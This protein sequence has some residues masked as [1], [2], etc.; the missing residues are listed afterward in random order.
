VF[1]LRPETDVSGRTTFR[2]I[3]IM[4]D[5]DR[6]FFPADKVAN[7]ARTMIRSLGMDPDEMRTLDRSLSNGAALVQRLSMMPLQEGDVAG[8]IAG[9]TT[10]AALQTLKD[11]EDE[12]GK[13]VT[14]LLAGLE[15]VVERFS[16]LLGGTTNMF[17]NTANATVEAGATP[18]QVLYENLF[19]PTVR[20]ERAPVNV[21]G[22]LSA[23]VDQIRG[24]VA[25]SFAGGQVHPAVVGAGVDVGTYKRLYAAINTPTPGNV[26]EMLSFI[27]RHPVVADVNQKG[28]QV[29]A[30]WAVEMRSALSKNNQQTML[31]VSPNHPQ[32]VAN[33]L[34][35][36]LRPIPSAEYTKEGATFLDQTPIMQA[37][38]AAY[39]QGGSAASGKQ[40]GR[41]FDSLFGGDDDDMG[42]DVSP[43]GAFF[44][45]GAEGR[46][47]IA[48]LRARRAGPPEGVN[49][50]GD[51]RLR[52]GALA[53]NLEDVRQFVTS[54]LER[55]VAALYFTAPWRRQTLESW[56]HRNIMP[57]FGII[58]FR[59]GLYDMAL[60][61][62]VFPFV[63]FL[64]A[65]LTSPIV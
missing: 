16:G 60:G 39:A 13:I 63:F 51:P 44:S 36:G 18:A 11:V 46:E 30:Q 1:W 33:R 7:L 6:T 41:G 23:A 2:N 59:F 56:L 42:D 21:Q 58:G 50:R 20:L 31:A 26:D 47:Q 25:G 12:T 64:I 4:G 9:R 37:M 34:P 27:Q 35:A 15:T 17:L 61:I 24:A 45:G 38:V 57:N 22:R 3:E 53:N 32:L 28:P 62:K 43:V 10:W 65:K 8:D 54:G 40:R 55:V 48:A 19:A 29:I 5:I 14:A 52:F 49:V